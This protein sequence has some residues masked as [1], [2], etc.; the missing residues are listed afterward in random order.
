[1]DSPR[2]VTAAWPSAPAIVARWSAIA[3]L[4]ALAV[5]GPAAAQTYEGH[6]VIG[7]TIEGLTTLSEG[8]LRFY[9]GLDPQ[10]ALDAASL[11]ERIHR[12][13]ERGLIEDIQVETE[14]VAGGV[15]LRIRVQERPTL[16]AIEY[17][18]LKRLERTDIN[19]R[20]SRDLI[21]VQE[22][23]PLN[24]AEVYRLRAAIESMYAE[25]GYRL[26]DASFR[27]EQQPDAS[28]RVTFTVDEGDKVRIQEIDF[29]GNT[30][31]GDARLRFAMRKTKE[32]GLIT[33]LLRRD[34]FDEAEF[35]EDLDKVREIYR[36]AGYKNLVIGE[37]QIDIGSSSAGAAE[38]KRRLVLTI[39]IEEGQRWRLGEIRIEGN[40]KFDDDLLL[41]MF[42]RPRGGWLRSNAI[43]EGVTA[44]EEVYK[45]TGYLFARVE[46]DL[47]ERDGETAD[48]VIAVDEGDQFKIGR[49]EFEG[50]TRT[51]DKVIRRELGIAEG[52]IL[53][54]GA[55]KNSLLR[56]RQLE[57]FKVDEENPV[58]FDFDTEGQTADLLIRGEEG[59][60]TEL[61][62]GAGYSELD[63]FF[64]QLAFRTRN[65]LGRGETLGV[66]LQSGGRQDVFDISYTV[67]WFLDRPQSLGGQVFIRDSDLE[68]LGERVQQE[69][70]GGVLTY[71]RRLGLFQNASLSYSRFDSFDTRFRF[72]D[73][74]ADPTTP[75]VPG[76]PLEFERNAAVLRLGYDFDKRD[77]RLWPTRGMGYNFGVDYAGGVLGGNSDFVRPRAN[78]SLFRPV[79]K[80]PQTLFAVNLE[81]GLIENT[82]DGELFYND[83]FYLGGET[84]LR[85][86]RARSITVRDAAGRIVRDENSL[87]VG[88]E[89]SLLANLEYHVLLGG[90]FRL[91][92]FVDAGNVWAEEQGIDLGGVR[93]TGGFELQVNVPLLGAPLRFIYAQNLDELPGDDFEAFRFSIGPSF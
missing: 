62:F 3:L 76:A 74:D 51:R 2:Q 49:I 75:E 6:A 82:G 79:S 13:W 71:G 57:F 25:K 84:S 33:R 32:S 73:H 61:Q 44:V 58:E 36:Q 53:S 91:L 93:T 1:M 42:R 89:R 80:R 26:A 77:S 39:P 64:G 60:R 54:S 45:N 86:H 35:Q 70:K 41:G 83:R 30:V 90:P 55:L 7:I 5:A 18:G 12:L 38:A 11:N 66:N 52:R 19:E 22:G 20:V 88:G 46:S 78:F 37:P 67:P 92:A 85:G 17:V 56:I 47:V 24:Y 29:E 59:D 15:V 14:E 16:S 63:G 69:T 81:A 68:Y 23:D 34:L 28:Y 21:R 65:F 4:G 8:T 27:V 87:L 43:D 40:E 9:L 50:N 10:A 48:V 31:F 72:V